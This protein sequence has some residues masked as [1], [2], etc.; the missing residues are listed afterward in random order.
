MLPPIFL[1]FALLLLTA[2]AVVVDAYYR[3]QRHGVF[4]LLAVEHR[5]HYSARDSLRLTP[6]VA[7]ALPIPGAAAV[8]VIDL[9]YR[10]DDV[11]HHYV[12]TAEYTIGVIGPKTRVRRAGSFSEGKSASSNAIVVRLGSNDVPLIEQYRVLILSAGAAEVEGS[13]RG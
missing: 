8:R 5:M 13:S 4:R 9:V 11:A 10:S 6:R 3:R 2:G 1:L 7:A 12:F